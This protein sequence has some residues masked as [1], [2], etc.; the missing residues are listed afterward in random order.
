M[1]LRD[2]DLL[3]SV[4][5]HFGHLEGLRVKRMAVVWA[6]FQLDLR[7]CS[8]HRGELA[9]NL[10]IM[11]VACCAEAQ[12]TKMFQLANVDGLNHRQPGRLNTSEYITPYSYRTH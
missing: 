4:E 8:R 5:V 1:K 12:S 6:R 10:K 11:E 9:S 7:S 2:R 3:I